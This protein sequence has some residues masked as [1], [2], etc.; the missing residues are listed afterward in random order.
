MAFRAETSVVQASKMVSQD[1]DQEMSP[2][3]GIKEEPSEEGQHEQQVN[4]AFYRRASVG[5]S[6]LHSNDFEMTV[7]I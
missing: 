6:L 4:D 2:N 3:P 7:A 5:I 1:T